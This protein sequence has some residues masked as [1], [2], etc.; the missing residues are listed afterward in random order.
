MRLSG[1]ATAAVMVAA[2]LVG[3]VPMGSAAGSLC[4]G[5]GAPSGNPAEAVTRALPSASLEAQDTHI[6]WTRWPTSVTYGE[7][8]TLQG[9][10]VTDNGALA[11]AQV[12]LLARPT[13]SQR[14]QHID[15]TTT[16]QDTGVFTFGC[17]QPIRTTDYRAVY[18][19]TVYYAAS[20]ANRHVPVA[21]HVPDRMAQVAPTLFRYT[22]FVQPRYTGRTVALQ[23]R[24]CP[25][26]RWRTSD[27]TTSSS[28]S[29]WRFV[30]DASTFTGR[31]WFR[32]VV[33][34]DAGFIASP[35]E[36]VWRLVVR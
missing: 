17:L 25:D 10:V 33:P 5:P 19:G 34:A 30:I 16:D 24:R 4:G 22:G 35:S 3:P 31:C 7:S 18:R 11:D 13:G 36:H 12:D 2:L 32:A 9:Q 1:V 20:K 29:A 27:R 15:T 8:A 28:R 6:H 23:L 21:R 14:W 26:C